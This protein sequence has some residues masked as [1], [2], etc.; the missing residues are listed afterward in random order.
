MK[1]RRESAERADT[2][3]KAIVKKG[4]SVV[5]AVEADPSDAPSVADEAEVEAVAAVRVIA[6]DEGTTTAIEI[7]G[8]D[9][10]KI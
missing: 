8:Y 9:V 10:M 4:G 5:A 2:G 1:R 3:D 7:D 6:A